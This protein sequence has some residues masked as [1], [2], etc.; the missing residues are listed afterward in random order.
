MESSVRTVV[1]NYNDSLNDFDKVFRYSQLTGNIDDADISILSNITT[2]IIGQLFTPIIGTSSS[3]TINFS[4]PLYN[5]HS[6]HN[7]SDGGIIASTGFYLGATTEYFFDDDGVGN[8]RIYSLVDAARV[9]FDSEAG[10]VDYSDGTVK[11]NPLSITNMSNV[12]G[13]VL[14]KIRVTAIPNSNDIIPVRNQL[15]E[16][17]LTNTTVVGSVDATATTG[18]GYTVTTTGTTTTTTVST[19]SSTPTASGY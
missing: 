18:K 8:L 10:T 9:Y 12:D 6:G 13:L 17:D 14:G 3:Y 7:A 2:V 5:P 11:I 4:N 1:S 15:L 16:I 19:P